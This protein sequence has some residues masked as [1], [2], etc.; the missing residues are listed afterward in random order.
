MSDARRKKTMP[1]RSNK[2]LREPGNR[3]AE[4]QEIGR[5]GQ[6]YFDYHAGQI[7]LIPIEAEGVRDVGIDF[8]CQRRSTFKGHSSR[9]LGDFIA[10]PV[11]AT[12]QKDQR[13]C[14]DR[15]DAAHLLVTQIPVLFALVSFDRESD[16]ETIFYRPMDREFANE[17]LAFLDSDAETR[18]YTPK[19]PGFVESKDGRESVELLCRPNYAFS[20]RLHILTHRAR[21]HLPDAK[22]SVETRHEGQVS[23]LYSEQFGEAFDV[24]DEEAKARLLDAVF[25][26]GDE[27]GARL[28]EMLIKPELLQIGHELPGP[29]LFGGTIPAANTTIF[30]RGPAGGAQLDVEWRSA[31][32]WSGFVH[33]SGFC[34]RVSDA[35]PHEGQHVHF[36]RATLDPS[37]PVDLRLHPDLEGFLALCVDEAE[38]ALGAAVEDGLSIHCCEGLYPLGVFVAARRVAD[39]DDLPKAAHVLGSVP[40]PES[41]NTLLFLGDARTGRTFPSPWGFTLSEEYQ[42]DAEV[43]RAALPV[44]GNVCGRG[45]IMWIT[46]DTRFLRREGRVCGLKLTRFSLARVEE[47]GPFEKASVYPEL[48]VAPAWPSVVL[49][50]RDVPGTDDVSGWGC[51]VVVPGSDDEDE[52]G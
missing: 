11:R 8:V 13:V 45:V 2:P 48:V 20:L 12:T 16:Q 44:C 39:G 1:E 14:L 50:L 28:G 22:I 40:S 41:T 47:R 35:T 4:S 43:K 34:L 6:R 15:N 26:H 30:V 38:L 25:G 23:L 7:D 5:R 37:H 32:G 24:A 36:M 18:S 21:K 9:V 29:V 51:E 3:Y 42:V 31:P 33:S 17:L 27:L 10:V 46:S 49:G 52:Y 19:S